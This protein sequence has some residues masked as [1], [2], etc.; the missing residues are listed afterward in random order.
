[1]LARAFSRS[2]ASKVNVAALF[3]R[4]YAAQPLA[5][6]TP[7]QQQV[8]AFDAS[9]ARAAHGVK[10]CKCYIYA[11]CL[12]TMVHPSAQYIKREDDYGAHN[13]API[14]VVL[15]KGQGVHVWDVD[16]KH[17][18]DFLSA[19]SALNQGHNHPKVPTCCAT[20]SATRDCQLDAHQFSARISVLCIRLHS[21]L[22]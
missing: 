19:Y 14:P 22:C 12:M 13:Y 21:S 10:A 2:R 3:S 4:A 18:Y 7:L 9:I 11:A 16:G 20:M 17:Y 15:S 5:A 8:Q 6:E 1:M